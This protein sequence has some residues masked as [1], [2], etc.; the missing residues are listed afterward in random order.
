MVKF[1]G[2]AY[3]LPPLASKIYAYLCFDFHRD[4]LTFDEIVEVF[5]ASK[6]SVSTSLNLLICNKLITDESRLDERKRYFQLNNDFVKIRFMEIVERL[7][8][9]LNIIESLEAVRKECWS[10]TND[11]A[12][13]Y[14]QLL[15]N[16]I[17][18]IKE[19]LTHL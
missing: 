5:G 8:E 2:K 7:N 11:K 9:E 6:S 3:N 4:G 10:E 16:N 19:S 1:Y 13:I 12:E 15:Q 17:K 18:N 14:K